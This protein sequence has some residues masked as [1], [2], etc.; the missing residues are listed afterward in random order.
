MWIKKNEYKNV[1]VIYIKCVGIY[2]NEKYLFFSFFFIKIFTKIF[3][4]LFNIL[5]AFGFCEFGNPDAALRAIRLLHELEI[6]PRKLVVRVDAK[7]QAVLDEYKGFY[8][9]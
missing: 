2:K 7:T 9:Y 4:D 8:C 1:A 5:T 6:G 3:I